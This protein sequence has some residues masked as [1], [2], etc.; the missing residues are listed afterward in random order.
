MVSRNNAATLKTLLLGVILAVL[1]LSC[2]SGRGAFRSAPD[3]VYDPP[4]DSEDMVYFVGSGSDT[5][6]NVAAAE[7]KARY[8]LASEVTSY[9]GVT[10]TSETTIEARETLETY[11]AEIR[12]SITQESEAR[13]QDFRVTDKWIDQREGE[14]VLVYLLGEYSKSSLIEEQQRLRN[15]LKE[16]LNAVEGPEKEGD[17]LFSRGQYYPA[18]LQYLKAAAAAI[19]A[20]VDN[21]DVKFIRNMQKARDA[22]RPLQFTKL[23]DGLD[24]ILGVPFPTGFRLSIAD[25]AGTRIGITHKGRD[26]Q[27]KTKVTTDSIQADDTGL[28]VYSLPAPRIAGEGSI[29]LYLDFR[30]A[31]EP[32]EDVPSGLLNEVESFEQLVSQKRATFSYRV[33]SKARDIPTGIMI[34]DVDMVGNSRESDDTASGVLEILTESGFIIVPVSDRFQLNGINDGEIMAKAK[35]MYGDAIE[36]LIYGVIQIADFSEDED[37][38]LIKVEGTVKVADLASGTLILSESGSKW[39]R[40]N[41]T[42]SVMSAAFKSIG[43]ELGR[44]LVSQLQ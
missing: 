13:F 21:R 40:G 25:G 34:Q 22:V 14:V 26:E 11:E 28:A 17:L 36:R 24:T 20:D 4:E 38:Y 37:Q 32:L 33:Y 7:E 15:L 41:N 5:S 6:G 16:R 3:W 10:V 19:T 44:A 29:I 1:Y 8:S 31:L 42:V 27:G 9:I 12:E 39:S 2:A 23:N 43:H 30:D 35:L 18:A